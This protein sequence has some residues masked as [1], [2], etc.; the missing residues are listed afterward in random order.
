MDAREDA[1][2]D[3]REDAPRARHLSYLARPFALGTGTHV[4]ERHDVGVGRRVRGLRAR[5]EPAR[6]G[7]ARHISR[8]AAGERRPHGGER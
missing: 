7:G 2:R 6:A 3:A 4:A 5:G 8:A 1:R